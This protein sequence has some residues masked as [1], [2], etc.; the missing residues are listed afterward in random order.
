MGYKMI[1]ETPFDTEF[2]LNI[3]LVCLPKAVH[4]MVRLVS[5]ITV[6]RASIQIK[7]DLGL[8]LGMILFTS[9]FLKTSK[10][11]L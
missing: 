1:S 3:F 9:L 5:L 6:N 11:N 7:C 8:S 10:G 4:R 2:L